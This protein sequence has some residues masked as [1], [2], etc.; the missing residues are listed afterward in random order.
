MSGRR[1]HAVSQSNPL[2][3]ITVVE[4][5]DADVPVGVEGGCVRQGAIAPGVG[6]AYNG[7]TGLVTPQAEKMGGRRGPSRRKIY[8]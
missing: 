6:P 8:E 4:V 3:P 5:V 7:L 2:R 1:L